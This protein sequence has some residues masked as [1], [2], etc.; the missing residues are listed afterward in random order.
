MIALFKFEYCFSQSKVKITQEYGLL[1][2][3]KKRV[4][5]HSKQQEVDQ[6]NKIIHNHEA[7]QPD[8]NINIR[9]QKVESVKLFT[10]LGC[11]VSR[12][13]KRDEEINTVNESIHSFQYV[14]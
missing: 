9:N 13:Q 1:M 5:W 11:G 8:F 3:V 14:T 6:N 12:D 7:D 2:S 4:L 10:Y